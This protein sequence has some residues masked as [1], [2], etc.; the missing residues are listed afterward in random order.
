[1]TV[2]LKEL[3]VCPQEEAHLYERIEARCVVATAGQ[4][5]TSDGCGYNRRIRTRPG[6]RGGVIQYISVSRRYTEG[7][8]AELWQERVWVSRGDCGC[9]AST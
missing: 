5:A 9:L 2:Y 3:A 6:T 4:T 8:L 7:F 1:M